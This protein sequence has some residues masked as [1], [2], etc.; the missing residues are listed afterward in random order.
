MKIKRAV[1]GFTIV[2]VLIVVIVIGIL[3]TVTIVAYNGVINNGRNAAAKTTAAD[4]ASAVAVHY[5]RNG[6]YPATLGEVG[7]EASGDTTYAYA[8]TSTTFCAGVTVKDVT[9]Y[10]SNDSDTPSQ[11]D[12]GAEPEDP[13]DPEDIPLPTPIAEWKFNEGSGGTAADTSG[14]GNTLTAVGSPWTASGKTGAGFNPTL[15]NYFTRTSGLGSD[16]HN[17]WTVTLWFQ[18]TGALSTTYGQFMYDNNEFWADIR[19]TNQWGY[20]GA[21][22]ASALPQNEW[23]H[24]AFAV[25]ATGFSSAKMTFYLDGVYSHETNLSGDS[26]FFDEGANWMIGRGPGGVDGAVKGYMD[27]LRIYQET[28]TQAEIQAN[29][30]L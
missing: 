19:N 13:E 22:S 24:L 7:F 18:R 6:A 21:Y 3:A 26:R 30:N 17:N 15:A 23:H 11:T 5:T 16:N 9:Y 2:E 25:E 10:V 29:A 8:V 12:C 1:S 28:L 4:I 14:N 27:D 20:A